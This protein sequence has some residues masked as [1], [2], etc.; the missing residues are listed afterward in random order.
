MKPKKMHQNINKYITNKNRHQQKVVPCQKKTMQLR[1]QHRHGLSIRMLWTWN[2]F[3]HPEKIEVNW[4]HLLEECQRG[5][6]T[7]KGIEILCATCLWGTI[8]ETFGLPKWWW[9]ENDDIQTSLMLRSFFNT[10]SSTILLRWTFLR[11]ITCQKDLQHP[12]LFLRCIL[13]DFVAPVLTPL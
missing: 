1:L 13:A 11:T 4:Y 5:F 7:K 12:L 8:P 2:M 9:L 3:W 6:G 10:Q